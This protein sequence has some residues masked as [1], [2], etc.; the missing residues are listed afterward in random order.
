MNLDDLRRVVQEVLEEQERL[1]GQSV[2]KSDQ[3]TMAR[4]KG[5]DIASG[6]A[7]SGVTTRER[8]IMVDLEKIIAAIA[9]KDDLA[10]YRSA[11]QA[12]VDKIRKSAGV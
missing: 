5:K 10:K 9:E 12:V 11:L 1:G 7:L 6:D 8:A 2:S 3:A 4:Q